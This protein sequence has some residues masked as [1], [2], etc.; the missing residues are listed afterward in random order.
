MEKFEA[1]LHNE[2]LSLQAKGLF[3]YLSQKK[4]NYNFSIRRLVSELK[5]GVT[6][7]TSTIQELESKGYLCRVQKRNE[8]G[9]QYIRIKLSYMPITFKK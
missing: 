7:I 9:H 8:K 2:N 4:P 1:I 3:I 5:E 6:S